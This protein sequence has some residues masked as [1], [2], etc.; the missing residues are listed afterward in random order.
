VLRA[1]AEFHERGGET[2]ALHM[3]LE[4]SATDAR[5][6]LATGRFDA[7]LFEV[8]S[9]VAELRGA[10]D[11]ALVAQATLAALSGEEVPVSG[12]G[13][14]AGDPKLDE[15]LAPDLLNGAFRALLKKSGDILDQAYPVDLRSIR[16]APLP[17][18]SGAFVGFVRQLADSFGVRGLEVLASPALGPVC[19]PIGSDPPTLVFGQALL[20]SNDD[21]ARYFLIIRSLKVL[22]ARAAALSRT[23][24]IEL[25]PVLAGYLGMFAPNFAPQGVDAKKLAEAQQRLKN[26]PRRRMDDDVQT[27]ALEVIG[28]IGNRA[29]QVATA[30]HQWGNRTGLLALGSPTA[31]LRGLAFSAG[32]TGGPP[33]EGA[34]RIKWVIRNPEARDLATFSVSEAYADARKRVGL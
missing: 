10:T 1:I 6:A 4:R 5:R 11:T 23:A 12:A 9:T 22:Q 2:R 21:A 7:G 14:N 34:E 16:A 29:S 20:D 15:V 8:I 31:S 17:L 18:E 33:T 30:L 27:L 26:V 25:W 13:P 28:A 3:L 19:M 24:P 32:L